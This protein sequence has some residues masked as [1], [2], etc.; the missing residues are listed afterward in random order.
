MLL[1]QMDCQ[2]ARCSEKELNPLGPAWFNRGSLRL[3]LQV[4]DTCHSVE[5]LCHLFVKKIAVAPLKRI[6]PK[7][8]LP[9]ARIMRHLIDNGSGV[10]AF[11]C[12][13]VVK[14]MSSICGR[15]LTISG[16]ICR[17]SMIAALKLAHRNGRRSLQA[18]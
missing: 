2:A 10:D 3:L 1:S 13:R 11:G 4:I 7:V 9:P 18:A 17:I 12:R 14:G 16:Q 8:P 5:N 6:G 15:E